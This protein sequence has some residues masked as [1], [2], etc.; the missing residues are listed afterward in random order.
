MKIA[1]LYNGYRPFSDDAKIISAVKRS[2]YF[3]EA[4]EDIS[5]AMMVQLFNT[6]TQRTYLVSTGRRVYKILDDRRSKRPKIS[7]SRRTDKVFD[8][9][10]LRATLRPHTEL[11]DKLVLEAV[12][13]RK[14]LVSKNLFANI[15][16]E[17][18][19]AKLSEVERQPGQSRR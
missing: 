6:R 9:S 7:W 4:V 5:K 12:P 3:D 2:K 19:I 18:E 16:F 13:E 14:N 15:D 8:G 1:D 11:T 10:K 17:D